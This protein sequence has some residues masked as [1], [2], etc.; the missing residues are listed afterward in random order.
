MIV[1]KTAN[2][3]KEGLII[4]IEKIS[5]LTKDAIHRLMS[6]ITED[7]FRMIKVLIFSTTPTHETNSDLQDWCVILQFC[8]LFIFHI[9]FPNLFWKSV[10]ALGKSLLR[11]LSWLTKIII[12]KA[13]GQEF[14]IREF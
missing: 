11:F 14:Q 4:S 12:S 2:H 6:R 10:C 9:L 13:L 5:P 1:N 3:S 7:C 8:F